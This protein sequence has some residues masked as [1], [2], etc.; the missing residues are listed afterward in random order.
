M[1]LCCFILKADAGGKNKLQTRMFYVSC[2]SC[3]SDNHDCTQM[4]EKCP[5]MLSALMGMRRTMQCSCVSA[6]L[7]AQ[8]PASRGKQQLSIVRRANQDV[9]RERFRFCAAK[10]SWFWWKSRVNTLLLLLRHS[11]SDGA[12]TEHDWWV[13]T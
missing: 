12:K 6:V 4:G 1:L 3:Q 13:S 9:G 5:Q 11:M 2:F 10:S 7:S 8:M